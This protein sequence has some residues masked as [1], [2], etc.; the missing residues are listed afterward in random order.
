MKKNI[1]FIAI[2]YIFSAV[3]GSLFGLG[4]K[5]LVIGAEAAWGAVENRFG[6]AEV[7][8]LR[9]YPVLALSSAR[10]GRGGGETQAAAFLDMALSFDEGKPELFADQ[11]GRYQ[12]S[13]APAVSAVNKRWARAGTGAGLFSGGALGTAAFELGPLVVI[14]RGR[15]ALLSDHRHIKDF[16][17]EFWLYPINM[18][19]GEQILSWASSRQNP[20]GNHTFQRVQCVSARN[21]LRWTFMDFFAAPDDGRR[22]TFSLEGSSPLTPRTWSHHLIRFDAASGLFEYLVNG[23]PEA[24][25]YTTASGREGGE[26]Y[27]PITGEGSVLVLGGRFTGLIDEFR[28]YSAY[29][30]SPELRKYPPRGG[31]AETRLLDLGPDRGEVLRVEASGGRTSNTDGVLRNEYSGGGGFSFPDDSAMRF[32]IRVTDLPVVP[33]ETPWI[34]F[35]PGKDLPRDLRGRFVQLAAAFYPSGDGETSPYLDALRIVYQPQEPP[36]PP[37]R[38]SA[39]ARD[40]AVDLSWKPS[41]DAHTEGYLVYYGSSGDDYFGSGAILGTSPINVGKRTSI[42]IDGLTNGV[43]YSFAVAAYDRL[44]PLHGGELSREVRARPLLTPD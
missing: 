18:E 33:E 13:T 41:V 6:V 19:N 27:A 39:A 40:G 26:V 11:T 1:P 32:F 34:P 43:L 10:A 31:R 20:R 2:V 42:R 25:V 35:E 24:L 21:R 36:L 22:L 5:T 12:V 29:L 28:T 7:S 17:L 9:P 8:S 16:S 14:P 15:E 30:E 3:S 38:L 4:E 44:S 23:T 37:S